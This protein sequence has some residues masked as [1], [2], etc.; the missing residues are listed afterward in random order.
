LHRH[1]SGRSATVT[2]VVVGLAIVCG[3]LWLGAERFSGRRPSA[4]P[5]IRSIAV[6]PL[7]NFSG[8]PDQ[9]YA[10][11]GIT[12]ALIARL[13]GLRGLRVISRTSAMQFKGTRKPIPEIA[14][15]LAV[16]AV[17]TGS[18]QRSGGRIR[19]TA[20]LIQSNPEEQLWSGTY[21]RDMRDVLALESEVA[22]IVAKQVGIV[23]TGADS[24]RGTGVAPTVSP[25]VYDHYLKGR[26]QFHKYTQASI[27]ESITHFE[28]A[29]AA[30]ASFA[31]AYVGLAA[32]YGSLGTI[33]IGASPPSDVLPK[34][35]AAANRALE[36]DP[37]LS[38]AYVWLAIAQQQDWR[39][40][41]AEAAL[42]R[43]LELNPSHAHAHAQLGWWLLFH[44][45]T[46][47]AIASSRRGRDL[48]PLEM[49]LHVN[50][51]VTLYN[52]RRYDEATRELRSLL[53]ID[54]D[55]FQ[56]LMI[57]GLTL[58]E[59]ARFDEAIQAL[60]RGSS[61]SGR[62]PMMLGTLAG[63][64]ARAGQGARAQ[65]VVDELLVLRR[66]AT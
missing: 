55:N 17:V 37:T 15:T 32:A 26:F 7:E 30:D 31:P 48:D 18:V 52:A 53:T 19:I 6:L 22:L 24:A 59:M 57:L 46:D 4:G 56:A 42:R 41:E 33:T 13:G 51:E 64:Y 65:R 39:W 54:P 61:R 20:Q 14:T 38:D 43:A 40:V 66:H 10:A 5:S 25:A 29:I 44:G 16:D 60:E 12:E 1:F 62:S 9:G 34:A 27:E 49:H 58:I 50:L 21:D 2:T 8:D 11:D 36:L 35:V 45:R 63:A 3:L 23:V 28:A 47:E